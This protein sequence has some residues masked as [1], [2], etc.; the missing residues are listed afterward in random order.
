MADPAALRTALVPGT[1]LALVLLLCA[2]PI[3]V[4]LTPPYGRATWREHLML[5]WLGLRGAV[6][7]ILAM[8]VML[9]GAPHGSE[10]LAL[11]FVVVLVTALVQG[12]TMSALAR[13]LRLV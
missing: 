1:L 6:P 9:S 8:L 5:S 4:W 12:T 13:R 10:L 2:R 7:I 3:S 11:V